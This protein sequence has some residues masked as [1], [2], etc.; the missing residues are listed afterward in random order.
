MAA[1]TETYAEVFGAEFP[2]QLGRWGKA[3]KAL[4]KRG[5]TPMTFRPVVRAHFQQCREKTWAPSPEKFLEK[6]D[7]LGAKEKDRQ[8]FSDFIDSLPGGDPEPKET[9][10]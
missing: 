6:Y 7:V 2:G 4:V 10:A 9:D 3:V 5:E 1:I 8:E